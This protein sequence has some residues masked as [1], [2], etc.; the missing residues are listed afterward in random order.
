MPHRKNFVNWFN[1]YTPRPYKP[2]TPFPTAAPTTID[3][4]A[5]QLYGYDKGTNMINIDKVSNP[6][7]INTL[8]E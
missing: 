4:F 2:R 6:V 3:R 1:N 8:Y 7:D 5:Q